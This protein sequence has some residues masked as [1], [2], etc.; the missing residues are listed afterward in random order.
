[1]NILYSDEDHFV[2]LKEAGIST[3]GRSKSSLVNQVTYD[4]PIYPVH[5]LDYGTRGP[6]MF[7]K[8]LEALHMLQRMW[9]LVDKTYHAWVAGVGLPVKG[10]CG[11]PLEGKKSRTDFQNLGQRRWAIHD[12][13]TL[14]EY[15]L[16]TGRTH[17]IRRH[18]AAMGHPVVGDAVYGTSPL[19]TG[20]GLHLMCTHLAWKHPITGEDLSVMVSPA[21]K[22]RR[23]IAGAFEVSQE[24]PF[25]RLFQ[26]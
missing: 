22:M 19:F 6:V 7:A 12:R 21:K 18:A 20:Q 1:M 24:S 14:V 3:H 11:M 5:R 15:K 17:Q 23:A 16:H 9:P 25:L 13:A 10:L 2:V 8:N 4:V 26:G